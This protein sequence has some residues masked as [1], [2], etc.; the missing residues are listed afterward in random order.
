MISSHT[1]VLRTYIRFSV[2]REVNAMS[3]C[4]CVCVSALQYKYFRKWVRG[5]DRGMKYRRSP[6]FS[7]YWTFR[8]VARAVR[9]RYFIVP[10]DIGRP[11]TIP[12][13]PKRAPPARPR[14]VWR[15]SKRTGLG[16]KR[17]TCTGIAGIGFARI[18]TF[19][20]SP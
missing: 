16:R 8:R 10:T 7:F 9:R 12:A 4:I 6:T 14:K 2:N 18:S 15:G 1:P 17:R 19:S 3:T 11:I 5:K 13:Y 20:S